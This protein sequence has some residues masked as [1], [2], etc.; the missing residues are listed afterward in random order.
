VVQSPRDLE[1]APLARFWFRSPRY[2]HLTSADRPERWLQLSL[3]LNHLSQRGIDTLLPA[4]SFGLK[5][6]EYIAIEAQ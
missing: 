3:V 1:Y 6:L 5:M 4:R 2:E